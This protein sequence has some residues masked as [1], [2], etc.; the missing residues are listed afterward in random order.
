MNRVAQW[1]RQRAGFLRS[2]A[3][4]GR[5]SQTIQTVRTVETIKSEERT[6]LIAGL[7]FTDMD[8]CPLCGSKLS[9]RTEENP[10]HPQLHE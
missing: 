5:S 4:L 8:V 6:V 7:Q 3:F 9:R 2:E 1:F 10:G